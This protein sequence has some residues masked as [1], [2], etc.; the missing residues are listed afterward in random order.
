MLCTNVLTGFQY[1]DSQENEVYIFHPTSGKLTTIRSHF[2]NSSITVQYTNEEDQFPILFVHSN[3]KKMNIT[4]TDSGLI[5]TVDIM[6]EDDNIE[7]TKLV[8]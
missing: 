1:E 5:N 4:Y 8:T 6:D 2:D 7:R 3:G